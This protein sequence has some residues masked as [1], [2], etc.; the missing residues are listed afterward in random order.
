MTSLSEQ[1]PVQWA[2]KIGFVMAAAGSAIGLGAIWKF[3]YV[4]GTNGGGAFFL[5]FVL[6]TI[7][8]GYPL[9]V[10]EFIFGRRNQTNAIDAYKKKR[11]EQLGFSQDGS[12]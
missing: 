11:R 9:L 5:I 1:K 6:F 10:G 8:L 2:S 7:L 4:A 12:A 3:P